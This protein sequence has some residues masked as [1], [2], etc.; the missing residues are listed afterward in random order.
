MFL[1][2]IVRFHLIMAYAPNHR[3]QK[4]QI[5]NFQRIAYILLSVEILKPATLYPFD[6]YVDYISI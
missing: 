5:S 6:V 2:R 4:F 3:I 1:L